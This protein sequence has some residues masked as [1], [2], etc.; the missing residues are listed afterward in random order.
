MLHSRVFL[1][2]SRESRSS[3]EVLIADLQALGYESW[4]DASISGG[5]DW[6]DSVLEQLRLSTHFICAVTPESLSSLACQRE[7]EYAVS[8]GKAILPVLVDQGAN[9]AELPKRLA[10]IQ[11]VDY[12]AMDKAA[13]RELARA[14]RVLK[15]PSGL[16]DPL[17]PSPAV[18]ISYMAEIAEQLDSDA[19][20]QFN[21]QAAIAM[22]L[23]HALDEPRHAPLAIELLKR[24]RLRRDLFARIA[25]EIDPLISVR[26][27]APV[28]VP[29]RQKPQRKKRSSSK[30]EITPIT[31]VRLTSPSR[32]Q[33]SYTVKWQSFGTCTRCRA[34]IPTF[35]ASC[36]NCGASFLHGSKWQVVSDA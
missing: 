27:S 26:T 22:R 13:L 6:W 21:E 14:M 24:M 35:V 18:P 28:P 15:P 25:D 10:R 2:Y 19:T 30:T 33:P 7:L 31:P 8:L 23:R 16:P 20:L 34:H 3:V 11:V 1:S 17:P 32:A 5:Q 29:V 36:P 9:L 4:Y 12:R